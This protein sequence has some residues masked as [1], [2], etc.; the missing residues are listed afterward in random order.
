[1]VTLSDKKGKKMSEKVS[2][3][4]VR[5]AGEILKKNIHSKSDLDLLSTYRTNHIEIM[6]M[7]VKT[8]SK[9]LPKP[10]L[11]AR[12]LKRLN[13][14]IKKL[15]RFE[16]MDLDRMQDIGG[17]RAIFENNDE[18]YKFANNLNKIYKDKRTVL[19]IVKENDYIKTPKDDGY[20]SYHIV[21]KYEGKI[22]NLKGYHIELQL[23]D[24]I[25]HAWATAVEVLAL[26]S[27]T[28]LKVG[29]GDENYKR[30]FYLASKL[31]RGD[32]LVKDEMIKINNECK[33]IEL[34]RGLSVASDNINK[35]EK[36]KDFY[37][38]TIDYNAKVVKILGFKKDELNTAKNL[39]QAIE[40]NEQ[41]DSVLISI[42]DIK[43]LKKAYP[44]YFL[45]A[46]FFINKILNELK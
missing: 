9:K 34:L 43:N 30:F 35:R 31:L 19:K 40:T 6:K 12:R 3:N 23:R 42:S 16:K 21:F 25:S 39:Y 5:K 22:E 27:N 13:S 32:I 46:R 24:T 20:S 29:K 4:A 38:I 2:K 41:T 28:N 8:I 18:V 17:V 14:I 37:I 15:Q 10:I 36:T 11:I 1:M 33:I 45:D 44:N 26:I 7:L